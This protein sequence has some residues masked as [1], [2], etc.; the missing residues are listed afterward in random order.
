M[1][2]DYDR[3]LEQP[4]QDACKAQDEFDSASEQYRESDSYYESLED[5]LKEHPGSTEDDY[6]DSNDYDS[7]V[8]SYLDKL[9][10]PPDPPEDRE[11]RTRGWG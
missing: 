10:E 11:Y 5:Y 6:Q 1:A 8:E 7:H 3:W 9:N 4:Y 2:I